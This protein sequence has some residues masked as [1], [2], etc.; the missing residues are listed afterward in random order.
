MSSTHITR[1]AI[2]WPTS[3]DLEQGAI[4]T[5]K[6]DWEVRLQLFKERAAW[7]RREAQRME[8]EAAQFDDL[9]HQAEQMLQHEQC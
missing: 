9:A 7:Y 3:S 8:R 4:M 2:A 1:T 6:E 5:T